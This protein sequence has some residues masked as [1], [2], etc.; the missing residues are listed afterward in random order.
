MQLE[1]SINQL[2]H[3]RRNV[4]KNSA[5]RQSKTVYERICSTTGGNGKSY[6]IEK[7]VA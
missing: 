7:K 5:K 6:L 1:P 4:S 2:I 3:M